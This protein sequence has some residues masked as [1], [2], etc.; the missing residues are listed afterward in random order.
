MKRNMKQ[1]VLLSLALAA[2]FLILPAGNSYAAA[3]NLGQAEYA[4]ETKVVK[5]GDDGIDPQ[6]I[7]AAGI[8]AD[9]VIEGNSAYVYASAVAKRVCHINVK[10]R[11][12]HKEDGQ[13]K[14]KVSWVESSDTGSKTMGKYKTL[15]ERG[16]YRTYAV[17]D[18]DGE[19]LTYTSVTQRY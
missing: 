1:R 18:V 9:L 12:Q 13:W 3:R 7:N 19:E 17:F 6:Y 5:I 16:L 15:T 8:T 4:G 11:L 2:A 14:T 10:M